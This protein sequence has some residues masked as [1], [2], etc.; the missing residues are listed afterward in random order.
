MGSEMC[1]RDRQMGVAQIYGDQGMA[2]VIAT[3]GESVGLPWAHGDRKSYVC[4][5]LPVGDIIVAYAHVATKWLPGNEHKPDQTVEPARL[6]R[7]PVH[8]L[9]ILIC[10]APLVLGSLLKKRKKT[11]T[12]AQTTLESHR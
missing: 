6:W 5:V 8:V 10:A 7:M 1:I 3:A 4:G 2:D 11:M 12:K 9:S